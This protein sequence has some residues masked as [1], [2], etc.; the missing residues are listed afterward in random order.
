M[1][2]HEEIFLSDSFIGITPMPRWWSGLPRSTAVMTPL[3]YQCS[4]HLGYFWTKSENSSCT[5]WTRY[6]AKWKLKCN[7]SSLE[8]SFG[9]AERMNKNQGNGTERFAPGL[10]EALSLWDGTWPSFAAEMRLELWKMP[11]VP[12]NEW[13]FSIS[14]SWESHLKNYRCFRHFYESIWKIMKKEILYYLI[15]Y[16]CARLD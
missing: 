5:L 14:G 1:K 9:P 16:I 3:W 11:E 12:G 8:A 4:R 2:C 6:S 7:F 13:S 10:L 15:I